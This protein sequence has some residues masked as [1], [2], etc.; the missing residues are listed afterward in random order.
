MKKIYRLISAFQA[1]VPLE[2][3]NGKKRFVKFSGGSRN[4]R[5][6]GFFSTS[7]EVLQKAL[8]SDV[9]FN[10]A[11]RLEST[12][13]GTP[14]AQEST[15][16]VIN[17]EDYLQDP[18]TAVRDTS[19]TSKK[20]AVAF[21]QATFGEAFPSEVNTVEECKRYAAEHFNVLF[22]KW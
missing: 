19:V 17:M 3:P 6:R 16:P 8:E 12:I 11:Y 5:T 22:E 10:V 14:K 13:K 2:L 1:V 7:S 4:A 18:E 20:M 15:A 9:L 21:I